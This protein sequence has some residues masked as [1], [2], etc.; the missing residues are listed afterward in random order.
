MSQALFVANFCVLILV[1]AGF[2]A[3]A[4]LIISY[5]GMGAILIHV[6]VRHIPATKYRPP[7]RSVLN[8]AATYAMFDTYW[9]EPNPGVSFLIQYNYPLRVMQTLAGC[10]LIGWNW[11]RHAE[12]NS[13]MFTILIGVCACSGAVWFT[14]YP[15]YKYILMS[16]FSKATSIRRDAMIATWDQMRMNEL[17][18]LENFHVNSL[19]GDTISRQ[20]S[21]SVRPAPVNSDGEATEAD[22]ESAKETTLNYVDGGFLRKEINYEVPSDEGERGAV[23]TNI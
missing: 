14:T 12:L 8:I 13:T 21:E 17:A 4:A 6:G 18:K 11:E 7:I 19:V 9:F 16:D 10:I 15:Y 1:L 2:V 3:L 20:A 5:C 22:N 23:A